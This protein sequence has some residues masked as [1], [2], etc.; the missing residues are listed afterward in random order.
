VTARSAASSPPRLRG[1]RL[2]LARMV[3]LVVALL[4]VA[5]FIAGDWLRFAELRQVCKASASVCYQQSLLRPENV[6]ELHSLGL[7]LDFWALY[8][9]AQ[10]IIFAAVW[11]TVGAVIFARKSEDRMALLVSLFLVTFTIAFWPDVA[12]ALARAY[13]VFAVPVGI[14]R[15]L[16]DVLA[17]LFFYLFPSGSFVPC[18]TRWLAVVWFVERIFNLFVDSLPD[19][20]LWFQ[21]LFA[22][23]F[24]GLL[25]SFIFAQAYRY[26]RVSGPVERQQTKWVVFGVAA[27]LVGIAAMLAPYFFIEP[28]SSDTTIISA[29]TLVQTAGGDAFML[30]I[31]LS[32]GVAVL[33][34]RLFDIDIL[35]NRT[36]VYGTLTASLALVYFGGVVALQYVFRALTG[37]ESQLAIVASTLVI[38]ALFSPLRRRT[39]RFIDHRFYRRKYDARKTL[40]A[41]SARLRDETDLNRLSE[42]LV[43]VL[44]E[45]MQPAQVSLLLRTPDRRFGETRRGRE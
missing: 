24:L 20:A 15:V 18:W 44:R 6:R 36:L 10:S 19:P 45:T 17:M 1:S 41:F 14:L 12:G 7:S 11:W 13:P 35:I 42:D 37:S 21:V 3:W 8:N 9:C 39:Q 23:G 33:R 22:L 31:P 34:S 2:V 32:I 30:L 25:V 40:E 38:A 29:F 26:L 5:I 27:A 4:A 16:G 43:M 28:L